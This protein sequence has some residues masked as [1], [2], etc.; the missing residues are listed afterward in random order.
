MFLFLKDKLKQNPELSK[1]ITN[2]NWLFFDKAIQ[3]I[4]A[5]F[6]GVWVIRYLGPE[7]YGVL[8]YVVAFVALFGFISKLGMD[9]VAV[10]EFVK[11]PKK[12]REI[13]WTLCFLRVIAGFFAFISSVTVIFFIKQG[14]A[15]IFWLA[16]IIAL[17]FIFQVSDIFDFWFQSQV[18]SKYAVYIRS[19]VTILSGAI[20]IALVLMK[21]SLFAFAW[22]MLLEVVLTF[23]GFVVIFLKK[24]EKIS[25]PKIDFSIGKQIL[26]D[27][28]P[29]ILSGVAVTI[30]MKI[31]QIMIGSM[32]NNE[33]LGN[34][35]AAVSLSEMWYFFPTVIASSVFPAV[36][37]ARKHDES[38]YIKRLQ[39][40]YDLMMWSSV[41]FA[42]PVS[43]FSKNI[44]SLLFGQQYDQAALVL[45]I[46][47]WAGVAVSLGVAS[48]NYL[49]A[50]NLTKVS[51]YRTFFG[52]VLNVFLNLI[53]IPRY[54]IIGSAIATLA[55]YTVAT[56]SVI[57]F[58]KSRETFI[59]LLKTL[60]LFRIIKGLRNNWR[61][62]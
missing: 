38:L 10:R 26:S 49:I 16:V 56:F 3:M 32:L 37:Y 47:V 2:I 39:D 21:S 4:V 42:V 61:S 46:Y 36:L 9:G 1:I 11:N 43:I 34:Y 62:V 28:W 24:K 53:L 18:A 23:V 57:F 22:V 52:A 41:A 50:E 5:F 20:R 30:Y 25:V 19:A 60:N 15:L 14:D 17:G 54:G 40:L 31:D 7:R 35:S 59:M 27:S 55:S 29:L 58:T 51:F 45:S 8:S 12:K 48:S 33:L 13:F 44:I 6:V